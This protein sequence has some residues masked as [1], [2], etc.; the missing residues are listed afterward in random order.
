[1]MWHTLWHVVWHLLRQLSCDKYSNICSG[2]NF[3]ILFG[4]QCILW[5]VLWHLY[6]HLLWHNFSHILE[7]ATWQALVGHTRSRAFYIGPRSKEEEG[8]TD[9]ES[10]N[11]GIP[12]ATRVIYILLKCGFLSPFISGLSGYT[13]HSGAG[14]GCPG[15][16]R[17]EV[18]GSCVSHQWVAWFFSHGGTPKSFVLLG[19]YIYI[20]IN[21]GYPLLGNLHI[22]L[23]I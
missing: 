19:W 8:W 18:G 12:P 17:H 5:H 20:Y 7:V 6:W 2:I 13:G 10:M 21:L 14:C 4:I 3:G 15:A 11:H 9:P 16:S 22:I 23:P 1:M